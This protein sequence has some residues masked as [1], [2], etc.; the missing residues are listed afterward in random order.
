MKTSYTVK[1][2]GKETTIESRVN[3]FVNEN[4]QIEKVEDKWNGSL[5]ESSIANV[6]WRKALS[7]SWW[8]FYVEGWMFGIFMFITSVWWWEV[9]LPPPFDPHHEYR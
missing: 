7:P 9:S 1:G 4:G 6:S 3:I 8:A 5:P 2:L